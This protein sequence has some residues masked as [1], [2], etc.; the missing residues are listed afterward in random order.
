M[1]KI[2]STFSFTELK[3]RKKS[4]NTFRRRGLENTNVSK[5][6]PNI[7]ITHG[8]TTICQF[9]WIYYYFLLIYEFLKFGNFLGP[10]PR[11]SYENCKVRALLLKLCKIY[12][13]YRKHN[14][15]LILLKKKL[16]KNVNFWL[17]YKKNSEGG[18]HYGPPYT[19]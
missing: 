8:N 3:F 7:V 19:K 12:Y 14:K 11:P 5:Y 18:A 15:T 1:L 17:S 13:T 2:Y 6:Q 4:K 10:R 16:W 9:L